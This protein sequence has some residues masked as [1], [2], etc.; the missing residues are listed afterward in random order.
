VDEFYEMVL[1]PQDWK[2]GKKFNLPSKIVVESHIKEI[3]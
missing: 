2:L 3:N 1:S